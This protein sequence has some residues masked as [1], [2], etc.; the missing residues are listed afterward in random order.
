MAICQFSA[1]A[2]FR[3]T[4]CKVM[5]MTP[6]FYLEMGSRTKDMHRIAKAEKASRQVAKTRRKRLKYSN[7]VSERKFTK[8]EG[9]TYESGAFT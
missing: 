2:T 4:L 7:V 8:E 9:K 1:G 6:S 3:E 5:G